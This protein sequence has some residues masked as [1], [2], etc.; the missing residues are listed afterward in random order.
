LRVLFVCTGNLCRSP[1]AERLFRVEAEKKGLSAVADSAGT[2]AMEG[3][4]VPEVAIDV[5]REFGVDLAPH[6]SR[7]LGTAHVPRSDLLLGMSRAHVE[8]LR[9][10]RDET[11]ALGKI[12]LLGTFD[13]GSEEIPDPIGLEPAAFRE[14]FGR[15][16]ACVAGLVAELRRARPRAGAG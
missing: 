9:L 14:T 8:E 11:G 1:F 4:T 2:L 15:I 12:A 16:A 10:V 7:P 13:G 6:R 3:Q 5:A